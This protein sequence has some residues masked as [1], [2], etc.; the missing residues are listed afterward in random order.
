MTRTDNLHPPSLLLLSV[1][2]LFLSLLPRTSHLL[3]LVLGSL[4]FFVLRFVFLP[5]LHLS[6]LSLASAS[7]TSLT[8]LPLLAHSVSATSTPLQCL[9]FSVLSWGREVLGHREA[10]DWRLRGGVDV[11][12]DLDYEEHGMLMQ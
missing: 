7:K 12:Q 11:L 4:A 2:T 5:L 8:R 1:I 6:P 10:G 3:A 9:A